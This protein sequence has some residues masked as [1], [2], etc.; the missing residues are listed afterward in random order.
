MT[1]GENIADNGGVNHA[2]L[3]YKNY[4]KRKG[5]EP[6]LP[7][8]EQFTDDQLFFIAYASVSYLLFEE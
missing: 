8:F 3:A 2:F 6:L 4:K 7:G 1:L 5:P